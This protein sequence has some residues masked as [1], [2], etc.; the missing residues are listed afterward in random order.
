MENIAKQKNFDVSIKMISD[1]YMVL[2]VAGPKSRDVM[3]KLTDTDVS[4]A[5]WPFM[6]QRD[7][8]LAGVDVY[9]FRLSYTGEERALNGRCTLQLIWLWI[10]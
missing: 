5:E 7:V 1:D 3:S 8:T 6:T 2:S 10:F 9:A 4:E